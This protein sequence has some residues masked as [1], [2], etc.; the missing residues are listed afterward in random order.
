MQPTAATIIDP[1]LRDEFVTEIMIN[2]TGSIFIEK[3]GVLQKT[4]NRCPDEAVVY[5]FID[6]ILQPL[7]KQISRAVPFADARLPDGSRVNIIV[8]PLSLSGPMITIRKFSSRF[9]DTTA[10]V[11]NGTLTRNMADFLALAVRLRKNIVISGGT[12][13]GKTTLLNYLSAFIDPAERI[14]TIEDTAELRLQQEHVGRLEA[15]PSDPGAGNGISIRQLIVNALRMRPDRIIVGECR[16]AEALDMLQAM[17]TGHRGSM[18]TVHANTPRDCLK[19]IETM[20]LMAGID[21]P[22][23]AIRDQIASAIAVIV[24]TSRLPDGTRRITDISEITGKEGDVI[25]LA[26]IFEYIPAPS[27][28]SFRATRTIP[29]FLDE[30]RRNGEQV[31]MEMFQ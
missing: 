4:G 10:L 30:A 12:G 6:E 23:R 21:I 7:G 5:R 9:T 8:P 26:P 15:R 25:T 22:L 1:F 31:P 24:Q 18:T 11:A 13:S 29:S 19:R 14:I 2:G 27:G 28:G 16:S 3:D 17:N 20:T